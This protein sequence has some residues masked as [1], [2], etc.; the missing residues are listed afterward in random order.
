[1]ITFFFLK[2]IQLTSS[3]NKSLLDVLYMYKSRAVVRMSLVM[4]CWYCTETIQ[5]YAAG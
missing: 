5:V 3:M 2:P 4:L 1:M